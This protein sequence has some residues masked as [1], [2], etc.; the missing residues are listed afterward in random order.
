MLPR[1][2]CA[3]LA[4]FGAGIAFLAG[5]GPASSTKTTSSDQLRVASQ[6]TVLVVDDPALGDN[7][8]AEWRSHTEQEVTIRRITWKEVAGAR[9]LPGDLIVYPAGKIGELAEAGVIAPISDRTLD[10]GAFALRDIYKHVRL[11][12]MKWGDK[13]FALPLGSPQLLL[14]YRAD[15]FA[16]L[17]IKPPQTWA[18]YG[19]LAARLAKREE[20]GDL[21]PPADAPW[22]GTMEPL[23]PG[24]AGQMLLARTAAYAAHKE[25]ISPLMELGSLKALIGQPPYVRALKEMSACLGGE[26]ETPKQFTPAEAYREIT[27][28]RCAMA[29][30]WP[31]VA[32]GTSAKTKTGAERTKAS[33]LGF[34]ELPG[35]TEVYDFGDKK[36]GTRGTD[37]ETHVPLLAVS[38]RM[39]SVISTSSV[40]DA[41]ENMA[42]WMA[43][44][45][46]STQICPAS[47][48][49]TLFRISQEPDVTHWLGDVSESGAREYVATLRQ[50]QE[51][52]LQS[53]GMRLPG[54]Q[55]YLS[56]L[57]QAVL[58]ALQGKQSAEEALAA[59]AAAWDKITARRGLDVQRTALERSLGL[60]KD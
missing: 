49:T 21:A 40:Q 53:Q 50:T 46:V 29:V 47:T 13:V 34:A 37:D 48:D 27:E 5:C 31:S 52:T 23:G 59:A 9:R 19:I 11:R 16:Q 1:L 6:L 12:E 36:W 54:R 51:R 4:F 35:A 44:S 43:G 22:H 26:N 8:Q 38:G 58:D 10:N 28:G 14:V 56:A 32:A 55:E 45:E 2:L 3:Q 20:L 30:T 7:I 25:Q 39:V 33:L 24:M 41:A 57:D 17:K 18:E 42:T 60:K 15:I